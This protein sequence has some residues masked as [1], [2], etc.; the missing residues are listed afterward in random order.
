MPVPLIAAQKR[1]AFAAL[2][3]GPATRRYSTPPRGC[4]RMAPAAAG[5]QQ[6]AMLARGRVQGAAAP[7]EWR[8]AEIE[9]RTR[10]ADR[11]PARARHRR[12]RRP[13]RRCRAPPAAGLRARWRRGGAGGGA[14]APAAAGG[15][16]R[17]A[18]CA[19]RVRLRRGRG[20]RRP[21]AARTAARRR[22]RAGVCRLI[23]PVMSSTLCSSAAMRASSRSRSAV[24]TR[25]VSASLRPSTASSGRAGLMP[26]GRTTSRMLQRRM[27]GAV[28]PRLGRA[29]KDRQ[30]QRHC[31]DQAPYEHPQEIAHPK[32]PLLQRDQR[33]HRPLSHV[34]HR[35]SRCWEPSP[36]PNH[37]VESISRIRS[38][39]A[40]LE[41]SIG[42]SALFSAAPLGYDGPG[43]LRENR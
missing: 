14:A 41:F 12:A 27:P 2:A 11:R 7:S 21:P 42:C 32:R 15:W 25:T 10:A 26:D 35:I 8:A 36:C 40:S 43:D 17:A 31:R 3:I 39:G 33:A 18:S 30:R 34:P 38:G 6:R 23:E 19:G 16:R 28:R 37:F 20:S 29:G 9:R 24:S 1:A 13:A 22:H 4:S 5:L